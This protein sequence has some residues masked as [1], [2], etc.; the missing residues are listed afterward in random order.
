MET[1]VRNTLE[2]F[3]TMELI[4]PINMSEQKK[5]QNQINLVQL[6]CTQI[7]NASPEVN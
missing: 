3:M 4:K 5:S 7:T 6:F 2:A 1:K